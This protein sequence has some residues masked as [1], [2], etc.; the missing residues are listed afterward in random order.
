MAGLAGGGVT[1]GVAAMTPVGADRGDSGAA[2]RAAEV[3][4]H[5][6]LTGAWIM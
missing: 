4:G 5:L 3:A 6:Y 1:V 2:R